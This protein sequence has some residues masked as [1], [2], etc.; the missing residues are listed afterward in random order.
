MNK[1]SLISELNEKQKLAVTR[2]RQPVLVIAGP[3]TGK[4]RTII[5]RILYQIENLRINPGQILALTFSNKAAGEIKNRLERIL[6]STAEKIKVSTFHSFC[7]D[8]LR[9][10]Y[11]EAGLAKT[12]SVCDSDY[13]KRL[14]KQL[15]I[16]RGRE[17]IDRKINGILLAFSNH[18]LKGKTLPVF[19]SAIY[20]EYSR[21]LQKHHLIDYD[22]ILIKTLTLLNEHKDILDQY[23]FLNQAILVDEFQD[24]DPIQYQIVKLLAEKH[25]NIFVVADDD[26]SIYTWRGASPINIRTY[27]DDFN[28]EKPIFL[29]INYRSGSGIMDTAQK[30]V[31][32]T[33]RIE[34]GKIINSPNDKNASIQIHTFTDEEQEIEFLINKINDWVENL[35]IPL[36]EI[37]LIYPRHQFGERISSYL[38]K[39]RIPHQMAAGK[40]LTDNPLMQK[41]SLYLKLIRDPADSLILEELVETELGYHIYKQVQETSRIKKISFRKA[42][43]EIS[44]QETIG[45]QVQ[46]QI[47]TFVGNI[48]NLINLKS[49]YSFKQLINEILKSTQEINISVLN[50][51]LSR[52]KPVNHKYLKQI[53]SKTSEI[54]I[55]HSDEK[56][57]F[58]AKSML[59]AAFDKQILELTHEKIIHLKKED[60]ILLLEPFPI[61]E[62][63]CPY[64]NIYSTQVSRRNGILSHLFRWLQIQ[65][66]P[67]MNNI[68]NNYVVFDLETT[69]KNPDK[70]G[71]VEIAAVKIENGRKVDEYHSLINPGIPVE[72]N[73]QA[74]HNIS[75]ADVESAPSIEEIWPKFEKFIGDSILIAHNGYAF[76]FK[77]M[78]R[79]VKELKKPKPK[80]IRYDSLILARNLFPNAQNSIDG[81]VDRYKLNAGQRHRALDDVSVLH[82]I[83][84]K[85]LTAI[86]QNEICT[87]GEEFTEYVALGNVI[88]NQVAATEDK[89]FF[90]AGIRKLLSPYS[91]I[92]K[93]YAQKFHINDHELSNNLV[94]IK[95]RIAPD[96]QDYETS[97]DFFKRILEVADEFN[98][99]EIDLAIAEFLSYISLINPQDCLE[100][101]DAVSLLTY[102]SAKGLE[103]DRV[104]LIGV[105]DEQIPSFFAYK[106][107]DDDDRPINEKI[108]EQKRLFYVGITR[109]KSEVIMTLVKNRFGKRQKSSPFLDE[110]KSDINIKI[111][112]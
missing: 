7:L 13:Q 15:M 69:D 45:Y 82:E 77:I 43:S 58:I 83:F 72:A 34:P 1:N 107:D 36:A 65:L 5:D 62:L 86:N 92:R 23:R 76:D 89:I 104:I 44:S 51:N 3:G 25:G 67:T 30:I 60:I 28:I 20:A 57:R 79:T 37:A 49:F 40:N 24:T 9:K 38:I 11:E 26:Q 70:C 50:N 103:F 98:K 33:D 14:L 75:N 2:P 85:L 91:A 68:F 29:D 94:R 12:F 80:N 112:Q 48:A 66:N 19:S 4:T 54:W 106:T 87:Q 18:I 97:D 99:L 6:K 78:D 73:A 31:Q 109:A 110:I 105:E 102:H 93:K 88:E 17:N 8:I 81:L 47:N 61:G 41:I 10:N 52:I 95:E 74:V 100:N 63:S 42:L 46:R 39:H 53:K 64:V 22:Q 32:S 84:Q 56:I 55:Y 71:I 59:E 108:E 101:I 111:F 27:M 35:H 21:Y 96:I 16:S 90:M